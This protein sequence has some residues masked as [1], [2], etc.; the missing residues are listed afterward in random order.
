MVAKPNAG[1]PQFQRTAKLCPKRNYMLTQAEL[2]DARAKLDQA[3]ALIE[4][5]KGTFFAEIAALDR[6]IAAG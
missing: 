4:A 5:E 3:R 1:N 6:E 2:T